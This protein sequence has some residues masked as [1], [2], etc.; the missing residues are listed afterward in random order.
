M[1]WLLY[2]GTMWQGNIGYYLRIDGNYLMS[3]NSR[4]EILSWNGNKVLVGKILANAS[5]FAKFINNFPC[6]IIA[7]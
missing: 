6:R 3:F 4:V 1:R 5:Q 2:S 7:L